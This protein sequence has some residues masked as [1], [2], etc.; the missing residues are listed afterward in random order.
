M[1][2]NW[3]EWL[4]LVVSGAVLVGLVGFLAVDGLTDEGEPP[5]PVVTLAP[6]SAYEGAGRWF[7]PAVVRN[8]G[9]RAAEAVQ[10]RAE[11]TVGG[12][13][14]EAEASI[15]YLPAGSEVEVTFAFSAEPDGEVAAGVIGFR[16]P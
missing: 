1:R 3:L 12:D 11:A 5:L 4:V 16:L 2:R 6:A 9:D 8:D 14:E 7:V 10:L 13:T 15:D